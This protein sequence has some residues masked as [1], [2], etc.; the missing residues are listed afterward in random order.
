MIHGRVAF[1]ACGVAGSTTNSPHLFGGSGG[2]GALG[3]R[4]WRSWRRGRAAGSRHG[5]ARRIGP[6]GGGYRNTPNRI[7]PKCLER[8]SPVAGWA[9]GRVLLSGLGSSAARHPGATG[10]GSGT[11]AVRLVDR[12]TAPWRRPA[13]PGPTVLAGAGITVNLAT[14]NGQRVMKGL[15]YPSLLWPYLLRW[16]GPEVTCGAI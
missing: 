9:R 6:A 12:V 7:R 11:K 3:W 15:R 10:C 4:S 5:V 13:T 14:R 16:V 1:I 2:A 8:F